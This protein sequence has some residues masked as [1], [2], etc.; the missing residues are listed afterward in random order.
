MIS[1]GN[2][3]KVL[4]HDVTTG[5]TL[6][7]FPHDESVYS[8]HCHPEQPNIFTTACSDGRILLFDLRLSREDPVRLQGSTFPYHSVKFNPVDPTLLVTA[9]QENGASLIDCRKPDTPIMTY[10][11]NKSAMCANFSPN[12]SQIFVLGRKLNPFLYDLAN[13]LPIAEFDHP[14]YWNRCTMKSGTFGAQDYVFSGSD[15]FAIYAWKIPENCDDQGFQYIK[16]A[17]F[18]LQGHQS[19]VNQVRYNST[20]DVLASSG[21]EKR[22]K[23]WSPFDI[24]N[25]ES[26]PENSGRRRKISRTENRMTLYA[27]ST[28]LLDTETTEENPKMLAFFDT[29]VQRDF[30]SDSE[31]T[32]SDTESDDIDS[33]IAKKRQRIKHRL[34]SQDSDFVQNSIQTAREVLRLSESAASELIEN[35]LD[36]SSPLSQIDSDVKQ[37]ILNLDNSSTTSDENEVTEHKT[38]SDN[39]EDDDTSINNSVC[40]KTKNGKIR[41]YRKS[42]K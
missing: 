2:D 30:S 39:E 42:N 1:G 20:F 5:E 3:E 31:E 28:E 7:I 23:L 11:R 25:D 8:I 24:A 27:Q 10:G 33:V 15:N 36:S 34:S 37:A 40:Q 4:V 29:L 6:D 9:N 38:N 18:V 22:I 13:P 41:C 14:G 35:P 32:L 21:V 17:D 19:I 12:G 26:G 16:R